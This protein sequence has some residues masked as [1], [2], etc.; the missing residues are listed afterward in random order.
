[1]IIAI[2]QAILTVTRTLTA[3]AQ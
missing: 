1:M 2:I 3:T